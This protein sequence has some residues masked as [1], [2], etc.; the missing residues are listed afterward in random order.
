AFQICGRK[1]H[2][3]SFKYT[4]PVEV[5]ASLFCCCCCLLVCFETESHSITQAGVQWHYFGSLQPLPPG[6][7]Q[8]S[9]SYSQVAGITGTCQ[10]AQLIFVFLVQMG[11]HHFGQA[12]PELL[13]SCSTC[14]GFPKCWDYSCEPLRPALPHC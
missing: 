7:K 10:H 2:I 13:T 8:F 9:A 4:V 1:D 11:F 3:W 14:L 6:F 5:F 12:G